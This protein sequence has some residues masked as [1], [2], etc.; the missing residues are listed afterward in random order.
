MTVAAYLAGSV[1]GGALAGGL[2]GSI[3]WAMFALVDPPAIAVLAGAG[4]LALLALAFDLRLGG[5]R[6]PTLRRQV[7]EDWLNRYRG[8][9]YGAGFGLQLGAGF[10]TIMTTAAVPV[11]FAFAAL[12][13]SPLPGVLIGATFGAV[14]GALVLAAARVNEPS[15]LVQLHRRIASTA[16]LAA[17]TTIVVLAIAALVAGAGAVTFA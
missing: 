2:A 15:Q 11:T 8:W 1:T 3:G 4:V 6:L 12:T 14:R 9:V 17:R 10:A 13:G 16:P 7:N 5:L